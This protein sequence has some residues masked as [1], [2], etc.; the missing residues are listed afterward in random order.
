LL[1]LLVMG[2]GMA[3]APNQALAEPPKSIKVVTDDNYPPYVFRDEQGRL[4]GILK[5][6]WELWAARTGIPVDLAAMDW[7]QAQRDMA[8]GKADAIDT[9]FETDVRKRLMDFSEPYATIDVAIFFREDL[10][11]IKDA[12]SLHGFTVGAKGG[13]ACIDWLSARGINSFRE[14]PSYESLID[15]AA[16]REVLVFCIDMPPARYFMLKKGLQERFR[17][18]EPLFSGQFHWAVHKG[19]N[20]MRALI[21]DGF[22]RITSDER[23]AI[24]DRWLG[25]TLHAN[26]DLAQLARWAAL[27]G[28]GIVTLV[29]WN[30]LLRRTVASR[31]AELADSKTR[32]D[33]LVTHIPVGTY[34]VRLFPTGATKFEYVS[35]RFAE[36]IGIDGDAV[37]REPSLVLDVAHP[38][39]REEL[40]LR[41]RQAA[42][43][44]RSFCWEGRFVV[45]DQLRWVRL[46]SHPTPLPD[47][48]SRWNGVLSDITE[49]R[50]AQ[51]Q[52]ALLDFAMGKIREAAY[53]MDEQGRFHYVNEEACRRHG[54]NREDMLQLRVVDI[55]ALIRT[56]GEW[57]KIWE[58]NRNLGATV[59]ETAHV[60]SDGKSFPV[61]IFVQHFDF[62]EK[63]FAL[64]LVRDISE[65]KLYEA[66]L[67]RINRTLRVL[68]EGKA[69]LIRATDENDLYSRMCEVIV[70]TGGYRMACVGVPDQ[71]AGKTVRP[72]AYAGFEDGYFSEA[73]ITWGDEPTG[74]GPM[75]MAIRAGLIQINND[76]A[77][78][79]L[80]EPWRES[81][82]RRGYRSTI[83]LPLKTESETFGCLVI[84]A[85]EPN[86]FGAEEV[87]LL[88]DL[89]ENVS[90]GVSA[91]RERRRREEAERRL[92]QAVKLEALGQIAGGVAHDF[93]NVLTSVLGFARFIAEDSEPHSP[94]RGYAQNILDAGGRGKALT[95]Q[96]LTLARAGEKKQKQ[97]S[98]A[99]L[100]KGSQALLYGSVS[101]GSRVVVEAADDAALIDG[102]PDQVSQVVLNLIFNASDALEGKPGLV[103]LEVR[104]THVD[105]AARTLERR[106]QVSSAS[107]LL[108]VWTDEDGT[109]HA[110][111]GTFDAIEPHVSLIIT[112]TGRG[113]EP[114]LLTKVFDAFFT[115]KAIG[116]G[117]GLGLAVVQRV[118]LGHGGAIVVESRPGR[119]TRFEVILPCSTAPATAQPVNGRAMR[120]PR[121]R[122]RVLVVDDDRVGLEAIVETLRRAGVAVSPYGDPKEALAAMR[123]N[124]D[125]WD[126]VVSDQAM[127]EMTGV[128]L[129]QEIKSVRPDLPCILYTGFAGE[130]LTDDRLLRDI[131]VFALLSKPVDDDELRE[132]LSRAMACA[133]QN[134]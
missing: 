22:A 96:I 131:G 100:I 90:F 97:F 23:K 18:T 111:L 48:S 29:A 102:D 77:L 107:D 74:R 133:K 11:G 24:E 86:A 35:P 32:Y 68:S 114:A 33:D 38:D 13:D 113:M 85:A 62:D 126:V 103:T 6:L 116:K 117:T 83:G 72:V 51:Q 3:L 34:T 55:D 87:Q 53:V 104:P 1:V 52:L 28:A 46:E 15:G 122:G 26:P 75:G 78:N 39:D 134:A 16:N 101:P 128:E 65:R 69:A 44:L 54:R 40:I 92:Q 79:P 67:Q 25:R 73:Q 14:Y 106:H 129:V 12:G 88:T 21:A 109:A 60:G 95:R 2:M 98:L 99:E 123:D 58:R 112:D 120:K 82:L 132:V 119:G 31:T 81:L 41:Y 64:T 121:L 7:D 4:Q 70:D 127:P 63:P 17:H 36:I 110:V 37:L 108:C 66:A 80:V 57:A 43:T 105:D 89:A 94:L 27:V 93:N 49:R 130:S 50:Q 61:E 118:V 59:F 30:W 124:P 42:D 91:I 10:N 125:G 9:V 84:I 76:T 71:D 47:G 115:T 20:A 19:D 8:S 56:D 5:D 45:L